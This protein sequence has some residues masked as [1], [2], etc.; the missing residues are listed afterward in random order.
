MEEFMTNTKKEQTVRVRL[1]R[2]RELKDDVFVSVNQRTWLIRRGEEVELPLCAAEVLRNSE[3]MA[4][5]ALRYDSH[6]RRGE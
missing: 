5:E 3:A 4:E 1:P 6:V 2:T